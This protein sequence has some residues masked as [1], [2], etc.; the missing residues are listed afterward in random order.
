MSGRDYAVPN[1]NE[2]LI[3][4]I[5]QDPYQIIGGKTGYLPEAGYC[6]AI[7]VQEDHGRDIYVIVLGSDTKEDRFR[8][9]K[10]LTQWAYDT[11]NWPNEL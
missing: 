3:G 11:Y 8:E 6:L 5:N 1:T 4:F 10:G 2:L 7:Q 9:V